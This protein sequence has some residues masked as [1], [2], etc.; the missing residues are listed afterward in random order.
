MDGLDSDQG[1]NKLADD[2][3]RED[4]IESSETVEEES[5]EDQTE[6][7]EKYLHFVSGSQAHSGTFFY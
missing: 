6:V 5:N 4:F 3:N 7:P 1:Q 2:L